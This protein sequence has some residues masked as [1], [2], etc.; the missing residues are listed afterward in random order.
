VAEGVD[1][2]E[3]D[4]EKGRREEAAEGGGM[5]Q[6][7]LVN[8]V[9]RVPKE[10]ACAEAIGGDGGSRAVACEDVFGEGFVADSVGHVVRAEERT[11]FDGI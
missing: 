11:G 5:E 9:E 4:E 1:G 8:G 3:P 2:R 10:A 6:S 7:G